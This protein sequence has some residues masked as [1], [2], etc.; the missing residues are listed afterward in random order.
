MAGRGPAPLRRSAALVGHD[1]LP[2]SHQLPRRPGERQPVT[3]DKSLDVEGKNRDVVAREKIVEIVRRRQVELV[4]ERDG[5]PGFNL[6][7]LAHARSHE[8]AALADVGEP[9]VG[10][11]GAGQL[12]AGNEGR[13]ESARRGIDAHTITAV[14]DG[15]QLAGGPSPA[16][17]ILDVFFED[18]G[19]RLLTQPAGDDDR[20]ARLAEIHE[21]LDDGGALLRGQR[22]NKEVD[23]LRQVVDLRHAPAALKLRQARLDDEDPVARKPLPQDVLEDDMSRFSRSETPMRPMDP[24]RSRRSI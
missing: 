16:Q 18:L 11:P 4:A 17:Q 1:A 8:G 5:V 12:G 3:G 6:R 13:I 15:R 9:G 24:G 19:S 14:D 21:R 23:G 22:Q 7:Q 20:R 10:F 2:P